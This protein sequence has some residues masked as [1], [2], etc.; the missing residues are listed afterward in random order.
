VNPTDQKIGRETKKKKTDT[1][2]GRVD[3]S[4]KRDIYVHGSLKL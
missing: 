2:E 1:E 3:Y 4:L